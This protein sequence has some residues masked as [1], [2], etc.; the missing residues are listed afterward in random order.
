[1][2]FFIISMVNV[3]KYVHPSKLLDFFFSWFPG[4]WKVFDIHQLNLAAGSLQFIS[5]AVTSSSIHSLESLQK[6]SNGIM[7]T[8]WLVENK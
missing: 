2:V 4:K 1:M 6:N 8:I 7:E 3:R 5:E